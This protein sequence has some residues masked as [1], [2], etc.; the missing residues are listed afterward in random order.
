MRLNW[1]EFQNACRRF[2]TNLCVPAM[3]RALD[4]N[5][6]GWVSIRE[7][8]ERAFNLL[9]G[10]KVSGGRGQHLAGHDERRSVVDVSGVHV[11]PRRQQHGRGLRMPV[12]AGEGQRRGAVVVRRVELGAE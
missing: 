5:L 2:K 4:G 3:W 9:G 12:P 8:D 11:G 1:M 6:S 7:F 10:F